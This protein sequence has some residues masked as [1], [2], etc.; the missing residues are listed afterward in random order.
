ME[1]TTRPNRLTWFERRV[2]V[3]VPKRQRMTSAKATDEAGQIIKMPGYF[4]C[5]RLSRAG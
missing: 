2:A 4:I 3:K 5:A 1:W